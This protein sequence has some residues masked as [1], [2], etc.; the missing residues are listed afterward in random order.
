MWDTLL[1]SRMFD[2]TGLQDKHC[3]AEAV[4]PELF[5]ALKW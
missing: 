1:Q 4:H 3:T 2:N 5:N